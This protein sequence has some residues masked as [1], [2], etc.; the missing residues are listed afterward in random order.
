M[1]YGSCSFATGVLAGL[2]SSTG[3]GLP[4]GGALAIIASGCAMNATIVSYAN[5]VSNGNGFLIKVNT[6]NRGDFGA[7]ILT[8]AISEQ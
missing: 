4:A 2:A 6:L 8:V 3:V 7:W 1:Y 5:G